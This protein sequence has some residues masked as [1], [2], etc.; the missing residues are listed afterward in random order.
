[1]NGRTRTRW[2]VG[3][4]LLPPLSVRCALLLARPGRPAAAD[5]AGFVSDTVAALVA[6]ALFAALLAR[7]RSLAA[8]AGALWGALHYANYEHVRELGAGLQLT[9]AYYLANPTFVRGSVF[10]PAAPWLLASVAALPA[11]LLS[12]AGRPPASPQSGRWTKLRLLAVGGG[13]ALCLQLIPVDPTLHPWRQ[14]HFLHEIVAATAGAAPA[15]VAVGASVPEELVADL[16]GAPRIPLP[17]RGRNVLLLV[18]ESL[19]AAVLEPLAVEGRSDDRVVM[20]RF[21][22]LGREGL[23]FEN[24]V[25]HQRQTNRGLYGLLCGDYPKLD[26]S[27][28]KMTLYAKHPLRDCLPRVLGD[29]GYRT[30]YVQGAPLA[31]MYKDTF[32]PAAGFEIVRGNAHF[33]APIHR[34]YW[35]VD[36]RT[37]LRGVLELTDELASG[38]QPWFVAVLSV[39]THHPTVVPPSILG[40]GDSAQFPVAARYLDDALGD[41]FDSLRAAGR[42]EDTLILITSDE[43]RGD[44]RVS[45]LESSLSRNWG[46]LVVLLPE[47]TAARVAEPYGQSDIAL[48][49][50]DYLGLDAR[51]SDF[52]GRSLFREYE[53][54]RRIYFGNVYRRRV[55]GID[56]AGSVFQCSER[57]RGCERYASHSR[58]LFVPDLQQASQR[59][60][61]GELARLRKVVDW[62]R[63]DSVP[64]SGELQIDLVGQRVVKILGDSRQVIMD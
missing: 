43:S 10:A 4:A 62:S 34:S 55:G 1:M 19:P 40:G 44:F 21:S 41:F 38:E 13:L 9:F 27:I 42:L 31:F 60:D 59:L 12:W 5:L 18:L 52:V 17:G 64:S 23:M 7:S 51:S 32:A 16:G 3:A 11:L 37:L 14:R 46:P 61:S 39:G 33:E 63:Q 30:A 29:A 36:D 56:S 2:T 25:L 26:E 28:A 47:G 58:F 22:A 53:A 45:D 8:L 35:G 57:L 15:Q 6:A 24:F 20:P 48:S 49:L 54:T 50:L